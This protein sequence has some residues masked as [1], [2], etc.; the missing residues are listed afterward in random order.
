MIWTRQLQ[1]QRAERLEPGRFDQVYLRNREAAAADRAWELGTA[2]LYTGKTKAS[3]ELFE[4]ALPYFEE[5]EPRTARLIKDRFIPPEPWIAKS[6]AKTI[7][8]P[9]SKAWA[10]LD[11]LEYGKG[12]WDRSLSYIETMLTMAPENMELRE[13]LAYVQ[14]A[15]AV[16]SVNP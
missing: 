3:A 13:A 15:S 12:D 11:A 7:A 14:G 9:P 5:Y 2:L 1:A 4:E 10:I 16:R 8:N 6:M